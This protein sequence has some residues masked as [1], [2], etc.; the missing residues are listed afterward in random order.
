MRSRERVVAYLGGVDAAE[1]RL[2]ARVFAT[3]AA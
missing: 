1:V 2:A 3:A